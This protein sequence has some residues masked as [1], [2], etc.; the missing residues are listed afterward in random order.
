[1]ID[2]NMLPFVGYQNFI[3]TQEVLGKDIGDACFSMNKPF[4]AWCGITITCRTNTTFRIKYK[5]FDENSY[6]YFFMSNFQEVVGH[7]NNIAQCRLYPGEIYIFS[8]DGKPVENVLVT[9][10]DRG[11][12]YMNIKGVHHMRMELG[13]KVH[14]WQ[15]DRKLHTL[16]ISDPYRKMCPWW[17]LMH[18][19][20]KKACI[21]KMVDL[22]I[23]DQDDE[24]VKDYIDF[25]DFSI[26]KLL[27]I[28]CLKKSFE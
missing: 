10:H 23:I 20:Q 24:L 25:P 1:V 7:T 17:S 13:T 4:I 22:K 9:Y 5:T 6:E 16:F 28:N 3:K 27:S 21:K 2:A 8:D 26:D 11:S 14:A 12:E 19:G 18:P 15:R